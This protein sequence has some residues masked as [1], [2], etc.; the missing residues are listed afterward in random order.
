MDQL[1]KVGELDRKA[2]AEND[3]LILLPILSIALF[4]TCVTHANFVC[5]YT[6]YFYYSFL[7][8]LE[9]NLLL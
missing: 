5:H 6:P 8:I 3:G 9:E 7:R 2:V 1:L 4:I